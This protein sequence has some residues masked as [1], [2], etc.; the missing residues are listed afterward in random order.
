ME[1]TGHVYNND[2][3]A[4]ISGGSRLSADQIVPLLRDEV[5]MQ[6]VLDMG[7]GNGAWLASWIDAGVADALAVDGAYVDTTRLA[8]PRENFRAHDLTQPLDLARR[9]DLVQSLEVAEHI[10]PESAEIFVDSLCR[11]GDVVL[12]SA[13][14]PHQGGEFHVNE[15]PLE[16]WRKKFAARGYDCFDWLRPQ[17]AG[18]RQIKPWYR[19]NVALYANEAGQERL[20]NKA[21]AARL[22]AETPLIAGGD[23]AWKARRAGV[24]LLP[25]RG[26]HAIARAKSA[27]EARANGRKS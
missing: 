5:R 3:Y 6:S 17:I 8:I 13:A 11:H 16:Y 12:F 10:A 9:F 19:F 23:L 15:Q 2:F 22:A 20:G 4:Y 14:V 27:I 26:A 18:N 7:A 24:A 25:K 21:R 1:Q